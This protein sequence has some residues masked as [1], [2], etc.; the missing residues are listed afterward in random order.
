M[1]CALGFRTVS[2]IMVLSLGGLCARGASVE[3]SS[4]PFGKTMDGQVVE[5]YVLT[6]GNGAVA[7]LITYGAT[8]THLFLPDRNGKLGDV[9]LGFDNL[10]QYEQQSPFFGC[11]VGRYANRIAKGQ[12]KLDGVR[13]VLPVNN[14]ANH[15][16]G[17]VRGLDKRVWKAEGVMTADGPT[18]RMSIVDPDGAE[19]Y[20]GTVNITVI[21]SL[22]GD[23]A[24]KIQYFATA[25]KPTPINLSHHSYFNLRDGG[26]TD[27]MGHVMTIHADH[28]TPVDSGAIPTG[29]IASV[30]GTPFDFT[31]PTPIG[32]HNKEVGNT[33]V[34]Y[35]HNMVLRNQTGEFAKAAEVYEPATGRRMEVWTTEPGVQFYV[36]VFLDGSIKGKLGAAYQQYNGFCLET[37]HY[38]DSP[39]HKNFPGTILRPGEVYRQI[40]EYRFSTS[41]K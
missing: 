1:N 24:L 35:D 21:Y 19:G 13:Y 16:H 8:V 26:V 4:Q 18:V 28:Y 7:R 33:P 6:N 37:Q 34:G 9:V 32:L 3:K 38:P 15:L 23:N 17:G 27:V 22:T 39:N 5:E 41:T 36:G 11:I 29:E 31:S 30:K 12:F 2:V 25:D 10:K 20:P 14:G 40:T